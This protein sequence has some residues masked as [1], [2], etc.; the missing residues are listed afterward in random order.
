MELRKLFRK[1]AQI[2]IHEHTM[3]LDVSK[4]EFMM[5]YLNWEDINTETLFMKE[6]QNFDVKCGNM[7][8]IRIILLAGKDGFYIKPMLIEGSDNLL[9]PDILEV[10]PNRKE[11]LGTYT[12]KWDKENIYE[13]NI[14][15]E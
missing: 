10:L 9:L 1:K 11:V 14:E 2:Q 15:K 8:S 4:L 3:T 5:T 6:I 13:L 7:R 12:F